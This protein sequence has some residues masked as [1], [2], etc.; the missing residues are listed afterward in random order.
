M[1]VMEVTA[2]G[3]AY[4]SV[5]CPVLQVHRLN[6][7]CAVSVRTHFHNSGCRRMFHYNTNRLYKT[8]YN[9]ISLGQLKE[10]NIL[11]HVTKLTRNSY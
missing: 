1:K 3:I 8:T 6:I 2:Y 11:Q 4:I 5:S 9:W 10:A 7:T